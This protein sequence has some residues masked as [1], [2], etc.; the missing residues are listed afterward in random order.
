MATS[1]SFRKLFGNSTPQG[2]TDV[3][4]LSHDYEAWARGASKSLT[5]LGVSL[6]LDHIFKFLPLN[7]LHRLRRTSKGVRRTADLCA[8][9]TDPAHIVA[10]VDRLIAKA[11]IVEAEKLLR[12]FIARSPRVL[13][14]V[15]LL[16]RY[17][18]IMHSE[19]WPAVEHKQLRQTLWDFFKRKAI[20]E[21][22]VF[23]EQRGTS[24]QSAADGKVFLKRL[25]GLTLRN[26]KVPGIVIGDRFENCRIAYSTFDQIQSICTAVQSHLGSITHGSA[27]PHSQTGSPIRDISG[28]GAAA[29]SKPSSAACNDSPISIPPLSRCNSTASTASTRSVS[30]LSSVERDAVP[31]H[32]F[33]PYHRAH[34]ISGEATC[35]LAYFMYKDFQF[36][37]TEALAKQAVCYDS[38][39]PLAH[40]TMGVLH[41]YF[42]HDFHRSC[43]SYARA[44]AAA[45]LFA[46]PY[47]S[48]GVLLSDGGDIPKSAFLYGRCLHLDSNHHYA[49]MNRVISLD[50]TSP[51]VIAE[52]RRI[53]EIH[54]TEIYVY[55][56]VARLL[57]ANTPTLGDEPSEGPTSANVQEAKQLLERA[58]KINRKGGGGAHLLDLGFLYLRHLADVRNALACFKRFKEHTDDADLSARV[59]FMIDQL[60]SHEATQDGLNDSF[61]ED[62]EPTEDDD[63]SGD[64]IDGLW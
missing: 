30:S 56:A 63:F 45:P 8:N 25:Q 28:G 22:L 36:A 2:V 1:S 31:A 10:Q 7:D 35:I 55:R 6:P 4:E 33:R 54:P 5:K 52:Y 16:N 38:N 24:V 47:Y 12:P 23:V 51:E 14:P 3:P 48:L 61:E 20:D 58:I 18:L 15:Q 29:D 43:E 59:D 19:M 17:I 9:V 11:K 57:L 49:R 60:A 13:T 26:K 39:A 40:W 62:D 44:I 32:D 53:M 64:E 34:R 46:Y 41:H 21:Y 42:F 50:E 37:E 27:E